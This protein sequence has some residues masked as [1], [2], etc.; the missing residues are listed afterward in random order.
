MIYS[1]PSSAS[2]SHQT[3]NKTVFKAAINLQEVIQHVVAAFVWFS[4]KGR[5][6][7]NET[8]VEKSRI[9]QEGSQ[10]A[11]PEAGCRGTDPLT[12]APF[13]TAR[14]PRAEESETIQP[15]QPETFV[16]T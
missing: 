4:T 13:I 9:S 10:E 3:L 6:D 12:A 7:L 16:L 11:G 8:W 15:F 1:Q 14:S 5:A 2:I